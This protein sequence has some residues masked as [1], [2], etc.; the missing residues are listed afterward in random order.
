[1]E[2]L[3]LPVTR[4]GS[5]TTFSKLLLEP[6]TRLSN[7]DVCHKSVQP[8]SQIRFSLATRTSG[9][10][11]A[12]CGFSAGALEI[13]KACVSSR[14]LVTLVSLEARRQPACDY[15]SSTSLRTSRVAGNIATGAELAAQM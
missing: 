2:L 6:G 8:V 5:K 15:I 1:M 12:T 9:A 4:C 11:V 3:E 14:V 13:W 7:A 10:L